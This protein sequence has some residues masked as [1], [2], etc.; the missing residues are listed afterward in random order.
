MESSSP[1]KPYCS[2]RT[3][4][5]MDSESRG[6]AM[7]ISN[8]RVG[9]FKTIYA[10]NP[11]WTAYAN[12]TVNPHKPR[13]LIQKNHQFIVD[14][15]LKF[16]MS[17]IFH[18]KKIVLLIKTVFKVKL[19]FK[20][21]KYVLQIYVHSFLGRNIWQNSTHPFLDALASLDL[22]LS[23]SQWVSD[24]YFLELAHLRVF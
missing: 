7:D 20:V 24:W 9:R 22:K 4:A 3:P 2:R 18:R 14:A 8:R 16:L 17:L 15:L 19:K 5:A 21:G 23:V 12:I 11:I 10:I 13:F 6:S 1:G